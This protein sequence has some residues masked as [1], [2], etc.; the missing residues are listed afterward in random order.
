MPSASLIFRIIFV[1]ETSLFEL[2]DAWRK[3]NVLGDI[4]AYVSNW[5]GLMALKIEKF[6]D[7]EHIN[8]VFLMLTMKKAYLEPCQT[9]MMECFVKVVSGF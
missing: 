7:I 9:P 6:S 4:E 3:L 8:P 5:L 1:K 2:V